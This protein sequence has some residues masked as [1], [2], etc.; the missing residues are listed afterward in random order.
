MNKKK[1][2]TVM[3]SCGWVRSEIV[4]IYYC[5]TN[6]GENASLPGGAYGLIIKIELVLD[7]PP[8]HDCGTPIPA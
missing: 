3:D 5:T 4:D 8:T 6:V 7:S 1:K 2:V